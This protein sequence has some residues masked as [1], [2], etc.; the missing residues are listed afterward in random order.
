MIEISKRKRSSP[1]VAA[2]PPGVTEAILAPELPLAGTS[3]RPRGGRGATKAAGVIGAAATAAAAAGAALRLNE[4][5]LLT[6]PRATTCATQRN[7]T[8][9]VLWAA[10]KAAN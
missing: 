3:V 2:R 4:T 6:G 8:K 7:V 1:V 10:A 5:G 9:N